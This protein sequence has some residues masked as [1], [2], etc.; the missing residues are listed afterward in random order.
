MEGH[1]FSGTGHIL[2]VHLHLAGTCTNQ[3]DSAYAFIHMS[4]CRNYFKIRQFLKR[5][6]HNA[7]KVNLGY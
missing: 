2:M 3:L 7:K 1:G 5:G 4:V 6:T